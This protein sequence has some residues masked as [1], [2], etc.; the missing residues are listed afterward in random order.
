MKQRV[1]VVLQ[2][3]A[4]ECGAACLAM[5]LGY[6]G[7]R[8]RLTDCR[9]I[10]GAGRDG[11]TAQTLA[12]AARSFGL[13]VRAFSVEPKDFEHLS[14]PAI[15]HWQFNH[16][17]VVERWSPKQV[18]IVDPGAGRRRLSPAEFEAGLTGVVLTF[19]PGIH[20]KRVRERA[21]PPWRTYAATMLR[22]P[23]AASLLTQV[24]GA[25]LCLLILGLALPLFTK[26]I[27][28]RVL[29]LRNVGVMGILAA[30]LVLAVAAQAMAAC[31]RGTL[32]LSL[33]SRLDTQMMLGF[34]E[35]LLSLPFKFFQQRNSG[36]LLM[37]LS[38][39]TMI[40]EALTTQ[41]LS[42]I[43]DGGLVIGY[44]AILAAQD[45]LFC[46]LASGA[47][48]L[49][50]ALLLA[51]ARLR[52]D[53]NQREL[54]AQSESQSYLVEA[55]SGVAALKASGAED[56]ALEHW[57]SLFSTELN[58][59]LRRG[60]LSVVVD[61]ITTML[62][63]LSPLL[64]LWVGTFEV[65]HGRMSLGTMLALIALASAFLEPLSSL[66]AN[67]QRMQLA[68]AHLDRISDVLNA[69]PEQDP[70][71]VEAAPR[72]RGHIEFR[73]VSFRYDP[74][75]PFVLRNI[76]F[77]IEPGQK[78][79]LVGK[80]GSGKSTLAM[81]LLGLY[82]P[83]EG[84]ILIDGVSLRTLNYRAIRSQF[85]VVLQEP[86]LFS[87]S[88]RHNIAF[89]QPGM[90]F[91]A[92]MEAAQLAEIGDDIEQMPMGYETRI[93]EG[94]T[95]LSGGQRQ[96][97]SLARA[98]A[99]KPT[100]LVM[101]EATSHLDVVTESRVETNL[102]ALACT[103]IVI[104]HRLSTICDSDQILVLDDGRIAERGTHD[105]L[106]SNAGCYATLVSSQVEAAVDAFA[107]R[108]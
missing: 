8:V 40:R 10:C 72:L 44:L 19:E 24:F 102:S 15:A 4:V 105:E 67:G 77:S 70:R 91:D 74:N 20:F 78:T 103:R 50:I 73:N 32:L 49:Q 94:G 89:G 30:G 6:H 53:L 51:T 56:H 29:P 92:A 52:A 18:D 84:D 21:N 79:A 26:V 68:A 76:S 100:V 22:A 107:A 7:R 9:D 38:S 42:A 14:L 41:S 1:P 28:D 5:I 106:L 71:I 54:A 82:E 97:V 75:A 87:G 36:D 57:S 108:A 13:R 55:L 90:G 31:L 62:R 39:N 86:F 35:H 69:E 101:D 27:V 64:L 2:L 99:R 80:T 98:L 3:N 23:G 104:A 43:L 12:K 83:A 61:S 81:L 47:G 85:G 95:G 96:R 58:A 37:R 66:V 11:T 48:L 17:V 88:L 45:G 33:R 34:F 16:F 60:Q 46:A 25:S 93:A 63:V 65:L 59:A